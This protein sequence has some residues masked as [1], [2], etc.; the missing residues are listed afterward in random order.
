MSVTQPTYS[1]GAT[2][3]ATSYNF[4]SEWDAIARE[5][6]PR[7]YMRYGNG[8]LTGLA[9]FF[10]FKKPVS[11]MKYDHFE[12]DRVMPKVKAT[13]PGAA[14]GAAATFT[15]DSTSNVAV[16]QNNS[17]YAGADNTVNSYPVRK[18]NLLMIKPA[19]GTVAYTSIIFAWVS[20]TSGSTFTA[21]PLDSAD[22]IPAISPADEIVVYGTAYGEGS[23]A[24]EA[25]A[26]KATL[27]TNQ[28]HI[29]KDKVKITDIG[30]GMK[31]WVDYNGS[32]FWR[33]PNEKEA[34]NRL[35]N[36][37]EMTLLFNPG[38]SNTAISDLQG[39]A[40]TPMTMTKGFIQEIIDKGTTATYS[41]ITGFTKADFEDLSVTLDKQKAQ[42]NLLFCMGTELKIQIDNEMAD[43]TKNGA[44]TYGAFS[45]DAAKNINFEFNAI[46]VGGH[47][48]GF[49]VIDAM[50]DLQTLGASGFNFPKEGWIMSADR[51][52]DPKTGENVPPFRMRYLQN[53]SG[54]EEMTTRYFDGET[55]SDTG[56]A[57]EE[58]RYKSIVG[59][60]A[61][62]LNQC[63][64]VK[65]Q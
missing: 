29:F 5:V 4:L 2:S 59:M 43:A 55:S 39:A 16:D 8:R 18:G 1:P 21:Y 41:G 25:M 36:Y 61:I 64:Y 48:F 3:I 42:K 35:L 10:N 22:A 44:I 40:G 65:L 24:A 57:V 54:S 33:I 6:D 23:A 56:D 7:L 20:A 34:I 60:E 17:P 45:G 58:V 47:T 14:A 26:V 52:Q 50:N 27:Y 32:P 51:T 19:S 37:R 15:N 38:L 49:R 53:P 30:T 28:L 12:M 63:A 11:A 31:T 62:A 46:S 9:E 13:T